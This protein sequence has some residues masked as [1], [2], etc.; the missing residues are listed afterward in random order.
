MGSG[1]ARIAANYGLPRVKCFAAFRRAV[2]IIQVEVVKN[3]GRFTVTVDEGVDGAVGC[4]NVASIVRE[5]KS[6]EIWAINV[7]I[8]TAASCFIL[9][10][11]NAWIVCGYLHG[12]VES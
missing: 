10:T 8:I 5:R 4:R 7:F 2:T 11:M 3:V 6:M 1:I 9:R 12:N